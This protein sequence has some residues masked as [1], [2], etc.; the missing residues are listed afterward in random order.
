[1]KYVDKTQIDVTFL[2]RHFLLHKRRL[3]IRKIDFRKKNSLDFYVSINKDD[4][5]NRIYFVCWY[6]IALTYKHCIERSIEIG[7]FY[8]FFFC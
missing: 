4:L 1:M 2:N 6:Q 5:S 7:G 3:R 8:L